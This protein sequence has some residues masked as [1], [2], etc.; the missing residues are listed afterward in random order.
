MITLRGDDR[1]YEAYVRYPKWAEDLD[2]ARV[3][4]VI[5]S[6]REID[7]RKQDIV[8]NGEIKFDILGDQ[9]LDLA[10]W[11]T[12]FEM[13][14]AWLWASTEGTN[15][16]GINAWNWIHGDDPELPGRLKRNGQILSN[17]PINRMWR[18]PIPAKPFTE[19]PHIIHGDKGN[20]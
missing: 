2:F 3:W 11:H 20:A 8:R 18:P 1:E 17:Q 4:P 19:R 7:S 13:K 6:V 16:L 10:L 5:A 15:T 12:G 9:V 14:L